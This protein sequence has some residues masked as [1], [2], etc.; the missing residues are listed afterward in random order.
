[1]LSKTAI[2]N[3][4]KVLEL[5]TKDEIENF[6]TNSNNPEMVKDVL[7]SNYNKDQYDKD[8]SSRYEYLVENAPNEKIKFEALKYYAEFCKKEQMKDFFSKNLEKDI[9][10]E[11]WE[12]IFMDTRRACLSEILKMRDFPEEVMDKKAIQLFQQYYHEEAIQYIKTYNINV[13]NIIPELAS[14]NN[15]LGLSE[16]YKAFNKDIKQ[17]TTDKAF[18]NSLEAEKDN[19]VLTSN[20]PPVSQTHFNNNDVVITDGEEEVIKDKAEIK[21]LKESLD[22]DPVS[23]IKNKP[24]D[25]QFQN[26]QITPTQN[27]SG[28]NVMLKQNISN[29]AVNQAIN[30]GINNNQ[31]KETK[32]IVIEKKAENTEPLEK[33]IEKKQNQLNTK[34]KF[35]TQVYNNQDNAKETI[36]SK[37]ELN[38]VK[39]ILNKNKEEKSLSHEKSI[40]PQ[41][42]E[43]KKR[44]LGLSL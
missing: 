29:N 39:N 1:M 43:I 34:E 21:D 11:Q 35:A 2:G 36:N 41:D 4:F 20:I 7:L 15:G 31:F 26:Q 16:V 12:Q 22:L 40:K 24:I 37:K 18:L 10:P 32:R 3:A 23:N 38:E 8:V 44:D 25:N 5:N 30:N 33:I 9:S 6:I 28:F 14:L 19:I 27:K 13:N 17:E 42:F